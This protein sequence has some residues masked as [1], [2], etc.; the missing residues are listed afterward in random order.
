MLLFGFYVLLGYLWF[1]VC[2]HIFI[3]L[4]SCLFSFW[5]FRL[6]LG[7]RICWLGCI[8]HLDN[9][10]NILWHNIQ[11]SRSCFC[12]FCLRFWLVS[13]WGNRMNSCCRCLRQNSWSLR[14]AF[15]LYLFSDFFLLLI[16]FF[17]LLLHSLLSNL[18]SLLL[19]HFL[20]SLLHKLLNPFTQIP[21]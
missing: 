21:T 7:S 2:T 8:G 16:D 6:F 12:S 4:L 15:G 1:Q 3:F 11:C 17:Q 18:V 10:F 19:I 20:G 13:F 9:R 5:I 14:P